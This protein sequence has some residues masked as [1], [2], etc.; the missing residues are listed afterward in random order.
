MRPGLKPLLAVASLVLASACD[1]P[2]ANDTSPESAPVTGPVVEP[3]AAPETQPTTESD[4]VLAIGVLLPQTGEG[5][6]IGI[7]GTTAANLAVNEINGAGGVLGDNVR[8]EAADEGQTMEQAEAAIDDLL[9]RDVDAIV[10]PASSLVALEYL[11]ELVAADVLT[12]SPSATSLALDNFPDG[13]LFFRSVASD[14]LAAV[15]IGGQARR[16]GVSTAT[17]LY[18]DDGF[19]RPF[20]RAV[21]DNLRSVR[22]ID[23]LDE[24]PLIPGSGDYSAAVEELAGAD[25]T[26]TIIVI[27]NSNDGW[28]LL[29]QLA[30]VIPEPPQII[31]NDALRRAPATEIVAQL[32]AAFRTAIEG[33]SPMAINESETPDGSDAPPEGAYAPQAY[34]CVNLVALAATAAESD[35]P[36]DIAAEMTAIANDGSDCETFEL[37]AEALADGLDINYNGPAALLFELGINGDPSRARFQVFEFDENGLDKG[38]GSGNVAD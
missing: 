4:G 24:I 35:R 15:A 2:Q 9:G 18:T 8:I 32:P 26:G 6:T 10:G 33:M 22:D 29:S 1:D 16:T 11:D 37:C 7:P 31:V 27:A 13:G 38:A 25:A 20:A 21:I 14:S 12:C 17:V 34:N 28:S 5:A 23:V 3:T 30:E 36:A 19:G